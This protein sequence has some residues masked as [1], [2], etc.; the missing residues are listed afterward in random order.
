MAHLWKL[1]EGGKQTL[2]RFVT[3]PFPK[4]Q[5]LVQELDD[6]WRKSTIYDEESGGQ[7][8]RPKFHVLEP[9]L[10]DQGFADITA[11][12]KSVLYIVGHSN[13]GIN[14]IGGDGG[15]MDAMALTEW[16]TKRKPCGRLPLKLLAIKVWACFS[17]SNGFA[18]ELRERLAARG[19][20]NLIVVGYNAA[21]GGPVDV[22]GSDHKHVW[23]LNEAGDKDA[24]ISRAK[25]HQ[26][27]FWG[28]GQ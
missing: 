28:N 9:D 13:V 8:N 16:L 5:K 6:F 22:E 19:Y 2:K 24:K 17:G 15:K 23:T 18:R 25:K 10:K 11:P 4:D 27:I 12:E 20:N 3:T 26:A 21:T 14:Y 1:V 7:F